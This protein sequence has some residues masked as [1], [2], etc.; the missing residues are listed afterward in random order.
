[1]SGGQLGQIDALR[2]KLN[3]LT[4]KSGIKEI[5]EF[6]KEINT[7]FKAIGID[8]PFK[9]IEEEFR[10]FSE[11]AK[12]EHLKKI[13]DALS[14]FAIVWQDVVS[15][16]SKGFGAG[17]L[18]GGAGGGFGV[19]KVSKELQAE[20]DKLEEQKNRYQEILD[21][22]NNKKIEID[23][24]NKDNI[25]ELDTLIK[26][27]VELRDIMDSAEY[28]DHS[29]IYKDK[30][31][32]DKIYGERLR[33]A[34]LINSMN[35]HMA[36]Y[37]NE[38]EAEFVTLNSNV[39][40]GAI[41][42]LNNFS[43]LAKDKTSEIRQLFADLIPDLNMQVSKIKVDSF[44]V[45]DLSLSATKESL[46]QAINMLKEMNL[47]YKSLNVND[48][49]TEAMEN[50]I[51][52]LINKIT[53]L[54]NEEEQVQNIEDLLFDIDPDANILDELCKILE[55]DIPK[56]AKKAGDAINDA[57]QGGGVEPGQKNL[58]I[59]AKQLQEIFDASRKIGDHEI[60]F[61]IR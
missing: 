59:L 10:E 44:N 53:L 39:I 20:L 7:V 61:S 56:G 41:T 6:A 30:S 11:S 17:S 42:Y 1:M 23:F 37:G 19:P 3:T 34:N 28:R 35:D 8:T 16:V 26:K 52:S 12:T 31:E 38:K 50:K 36:N 24:K 60:G 55:V 18:G 47:V 22:L 46:S 29:G 45:D 51:D 27:Y 14:N 2:E 5:R 15:K 48:P 43:Q 33:V 9:N 49:N 54:A 21:T 58:S 25:S 4:P 32:R 57:I 13:S 40:D